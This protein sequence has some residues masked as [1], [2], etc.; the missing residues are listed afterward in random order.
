MSNLITLRPLYQVEAV[1]LYTEERWS[2]GKISKHFNISYSL[3]RAMIYEKAEPRPRLLADGAEPVIYGSKIDDFK[4]H[5]EEMVRLYTE[6]RWS[7][8]QLSKHYGICNVTMRKLL[9]EKVTLR[10][11]KLDDI[12]LEQI[13]AGLAQGFNKSEIARQVGLNPSYLRK[14]IRLHPE[15]FGLELN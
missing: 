2:I 14:Q 4:P 11:K 6:E 7:V 8:N 9:R 1:R 13:K 3:T 12:L 5:Q 15:W 10:S